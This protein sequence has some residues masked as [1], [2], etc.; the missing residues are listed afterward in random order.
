MVDIRGE[1]DN[2]RLQA[3]GNGEP[4]HRSFYVRAGAKTGRQLGMMRFRHDVIDKAKRQGIGRAET[5]AGQAEIDT[6]VPRAGCRP[7][8]AAKISASD[9]KIMPRKI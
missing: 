9:T 5:G 7:L 8:P 1:R 4:C 2:R 3:R 6:Y